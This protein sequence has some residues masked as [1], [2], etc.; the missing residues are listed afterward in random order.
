M[1]K[2]RYGQASYEYKKNAFPSDPEV[3]LPPRQSRASKLATKKELEQR[4]NQVD[5]APLPPR[6]SLRLRGRR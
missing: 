4:Q 2:T 6:R 3:P 1:N 5:E